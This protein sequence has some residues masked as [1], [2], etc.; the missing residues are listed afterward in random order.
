MS[1]VYLIFKK[2]NRKTVFYNSLILL[3]LYKTNKQKLKPITHLQ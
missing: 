3:T 1:K 2:K